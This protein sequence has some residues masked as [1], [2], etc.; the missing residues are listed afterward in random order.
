MARREIFLRFEYFRALQVTDFGREPLHPAGDNAQDREKHRMAVAGNHLGRDRLRR[1]AH[2]LGD[3]GLDAR[4]D[5]R[6]RTDGAGDGA[7]G[8]FGS[9]G[10]QPRPVTRKLRIVAGEF[11]A[12]G[13][14]L[15]MNAVGAANGERVRML[16]R[17]CFERREHSVDAGEQQVACTGELDG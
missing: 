13:R 8:D 14:R 9:R 4:V 10:L 1:Q 11:K 12:E 3:I 5:G 2:S 17:A 6:E 7:G 16:P 15:C